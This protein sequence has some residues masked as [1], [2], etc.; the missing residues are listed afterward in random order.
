MRVLSIAREVRTTPSLTFIVDHTIFSQNPLEKLGII[1]ESFVT[2]SSDRIVSN[3]N[4]TL[5]EMYYLPDDTA[6]V[7]IMCDCKLS[8]GNLLVLH[9]R[10]R[11]MHEQ[12]DTNRT[13]QVQIDD[14]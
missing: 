14:I 13:Q 5:Y 10:R 7:V 4:R 12:Q 8:A 6:P 1:G 2:L 3:G 9:I 11:M